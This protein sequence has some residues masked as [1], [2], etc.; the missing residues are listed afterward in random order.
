MENSYIFEPAQS[1][2]CHLF[3]VP[4]FISLSSMLLPQ[5]RR[6]LYTNHIYFFSKY[7][8]IITIHYS[9]S[10]FQKVLFMLSHFFSIDFWILFFCNAFLMGIS[11]MHFFPRFVRSHILYR[12]LD[13]P[14]QSCFAMCFYDE[15]HIGPLA[16]VQF[17]IYWRLFFVYKTCVPVHRSE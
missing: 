1:E 16:T 3:T 17:Q 15:I 4:V 12:I 13:L 10:L 6:T 8:S 7:F 5:G 14:R 2:A 11:V 9:I